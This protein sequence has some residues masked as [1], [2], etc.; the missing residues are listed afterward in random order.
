MRYHHK[1]LQSCLLRR[2][3]V[4]LHC[5][6]VIPTIPPQQVCAI[7]FAPLRDRDL[8]HMPYKFLLLAI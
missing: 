8:K 4:S 3:N 5:L 7:L 2:K 6:L 1:Y